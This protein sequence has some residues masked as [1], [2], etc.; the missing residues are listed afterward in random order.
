MIPSF[1]HSLT[2]QARVISRQSG[3][4]TVDAGNKSVAEQMISL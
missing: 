4:A 1:E 2:I 3:K